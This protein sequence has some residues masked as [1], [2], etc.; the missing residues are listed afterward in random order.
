MRNSIQKTAEDLSAFRKS[1]FLLDESNSNGSA[2]DRDPE[3]QDSQFCSCPLEIQRS[4]QLASSIANDKGF[5]LVFLISLLPI[6]L[7]AGLF[8]LFSQYLVQNWM[9]S[10][11]IC[12]TELLSTQKRAAQ[13]L[14]T[15]MSLN[16][17]AQG[18]RIALT[19]AKVELA[20][21][22]VSMDPIM[23]AKA[24][25]N[26]AKIKRQQ[27]QLDGVQKALISKADLAMSAGVQKVRFLLQAQDLRMKARLPDFF[28]FHL[29]QIRLQAS[30]LAVKPDVP[31]LAPVYELKPQFEEAQ[32][33]SVSW[34]SEFHTNS[35]ERSQWIHQKHQKKDFCSSSLKENGKQYQ[36]ILKAGRSW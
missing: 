24:T 1:R 10:L 30:P 17:V 34:I 8:L 35:S 14:S 27:Q 20:A 19:A 2:I 15:L 13:D 18:L 11:H 31:E 29:R 5:A 16:S 6:L 36:P 26:I 21:A 9:Q 32:A 12:R 22:T 4:G 28:S 25:A 33:L 7:A 23:I 3:L